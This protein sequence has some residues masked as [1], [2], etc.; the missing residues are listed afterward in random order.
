[1]PIDFYLSE[2]WYLRSALVPAF[3]P[4]SFSWIQTLQQNSPMSC[5]V[6]ELSARCRE[7]T[8]LWLRLCRGSIH[9]GSLK[10]VPKLQ[11]TLHGSE[12]NNLSQ[13]GTE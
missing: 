12:E 13:K 4:P 11:E 9:S 1:M 10:L 5:A 8:R 7:G 6:L 3:S 2:G